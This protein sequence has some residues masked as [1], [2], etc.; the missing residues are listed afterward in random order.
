MDEVPRDDNVSPPVS[1]PRKVT[2]VDALKL[3]ITLLAGL[4]LCVLAFWFELGRAERGNNLSWAYV[5]EW[6]LLGIFGVYMWWS[7]LHGNTS[8]VRRKKRSAKPALDPQYS[9]MLTA[10]QE[11][12]RDLNANRDVPA[13]D[14]ETN[15]PSP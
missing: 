15:H 9:G 8:G 5:F 11:Y 13:A 1:A 12:Q 2:G 10:W 3:H 4:T 7:F 14:D 6:P